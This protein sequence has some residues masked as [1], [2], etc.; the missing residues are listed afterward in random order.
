[1][2]HFQFA[3]FCHSKANYTDQ[4]I[5][6]DIPLVED[7]EENVNLFYETIAEKSGLKELIQKNWC[8][9]PRLNYKP[10]L[11]T[12]GVNFEDFP[13]PERDIYDAKYVSR[14]L[15]SSI[16]SSVMSFGPVN[17][18]LDVIWAFSRT[19][20]IFLYEPIKALFS[21][22]ISSGLIQEDELKT[23]KGLL[24]LIFNNN[25]SADT[26]KLQFIT[27]PSRRF[28][29]SVDTTELFL[30]VI[31]YL[32]LVGKNGNNPTVIENIA[33]GYETVQTQLK[34][35][36]ELL[37]LDGT[38]VHTFDDVSLFMGHADGSNI[39]VTL[40][41]GGEK[42]VIKLK[43]IET[44]YGY[45]LGVSFRREKA[46]ALTAPRYAFYDTVYI[47]KAVMSAIGDLV[48]GKSGIDTLSGPV[49]IV[50]VVG[51]VTKEKDN[52]YTAINVLM[53]FAMITVNL[54]VFNLLPFP[55]LDGGSIIFALWEFITGK[56]VRPDILA[57]INIAGFVLL[58]ALAVVVTVGDIRKIFM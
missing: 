39:K 5:G 34:P 8:N 49:E 23:F 55:A 14:I 4:N 35:G 36:D 42:K 46:T 37:K 54:G 33:E 45:K 30:Y 47:S 21:V 10:L 44:Q 43:P 24:N 40:K 51:E 16:I 13:A 19:Y 12:L 20:A 29:T 7:N 28:A 56:K 31:I 18:L 26:S 22:K 1:M 50:S 53:L 11:Y 57:Y 15:L 32:N 38:R 27:P 17:Y 25:N 48:T 9:S 2:K 52:P 41:R 6:F 58:M 3:G